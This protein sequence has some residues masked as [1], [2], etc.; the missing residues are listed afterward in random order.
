MKLS[1]GHTY[2]QLE[3]QEKENFQKYFPDFAEKAIV[4]QPGGWVVLDRYL[5]F[6]QRITNLKV[7]LAFQEFLDISMRL[8]EWWIPVVEIL[9]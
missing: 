7:L 3:G 2:K 4:L 1:N 9:Q 8:V 5:K 6:E